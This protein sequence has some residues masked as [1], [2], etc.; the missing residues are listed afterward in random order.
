MS[1]E[2]CTSR[3]SLDRMACDKGSQVNVGHGM[4]AIRLQTSECDLSAPA[5]AEP[6]PA[7]LVQLT[8]DSLGAQLQ[9]VGLVWSLQNSLLNEQRFCTMTCCCWGLQSRLAGLSGS[10]HFL[11]PPQSPG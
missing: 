5:L 6:R 10:S 1:S 9:R 3:S 7:S 2:P 4:P 11:N 8:L